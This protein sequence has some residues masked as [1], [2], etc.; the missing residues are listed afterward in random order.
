MRNPLS[1]SSVIVLNAFVKNIEPFHK[2][3]NGKAPMMFIPK[4][5]NILKKSL[6]LF[7]YQ[8]IFYQ[9]MAS[10]HEMICHA[11]FWH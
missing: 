4:L 9:N 5:G 11:K 3:Q 6:I 1:A 10:R 7:S 2:Y 8:N